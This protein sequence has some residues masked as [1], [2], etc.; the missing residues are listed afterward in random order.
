MKIADY[1]KLFDDPEKIRD[2]LSHLE[3]G[4]WGSEIDFALD[5]L[6]DMFKKYAEL[7]IAVKEH[8]DARGDDRCWLDDI[9]LYRALGEEVPKPMMLAL[10]N[11]E[12][13]FTRCT[14]YYKNRQSPGCRP[15]ITVEAL[16]TRIDELESY[17]KKVLNL[18]KA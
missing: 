6:S 4:T 18:L 16:Q 1:E 12:A 3:N 10:P 8:R 9:E 14:E 2:H 7:R 13:F 17:I 11:R 15:W 5:E